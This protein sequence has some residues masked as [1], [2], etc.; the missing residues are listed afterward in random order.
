MGFRHP[1]WQD[2]LANRPETIAKNHNDKICFLIDSVPNDTNVS[3][4][5]FE[6]LSKYKDLEI[7]VTCGISKQQHCQ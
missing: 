1:Y 2:N 7:E 5:I 3:L 6:K 4:K